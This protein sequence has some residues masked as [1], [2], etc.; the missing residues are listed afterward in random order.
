MDRGASGIRNTCPLVAA[1]LHTSLIH[2]DVLVAAGKSNTGQ[3]T[4]RVG[5]AGAEFDAARLAP[6]LLE[7]RRR[8]GNDLA[9]FENRQ[10]ASF[11]I[12]RNGV[13]AT[14]NK[15]PVH[16]DIGFKGN[17]LGPVLGERSRASQSNKQESDNHAI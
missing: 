11:L 7:P 3:F 16:L 4:T 2:H 10:L 14:L 6:T 8:P 5:L 15:C 12:E 9:V 17:P 1:R 13:R